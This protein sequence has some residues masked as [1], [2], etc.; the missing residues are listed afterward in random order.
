MAGQLTSILF[1]RANLVQHG[2]PL[3]R[4]SPQP[5]CGTSA[6]RTCRLGAQR[7]HP[8]VC[9]LPGDWASDCRVRARRRGASRVWRGPH[10]KIRKGLVAPLGAVK[11]R[12]PESVLF[13]VDGAGDFSDAVCKTPQPFDIASSSFPRPRTS[14]Y[15]GEEL[16]CPDILRLWALRLAGRFN[17]VTYQTSQLLGTVPPM[18]DYY[19]RKKGLNARDAPLLAKMPSDNAISAS[20]LGE[21][22]QAK[23]P[24]VPDLADRRLLV[25]LRLRKWSTSVRGR[26]FP[27]GLDGC[28]IRRSRSCSPQT[29]EMMSL[30]GGPLCG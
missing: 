21:L 15:F 25:A 3:V 22:L 2:Y 17:T 19:P 8:N 14:G 27:S 12:S 18:P 24:V 1:P 20:K 4:R 30:H 9:Q 29:R 7:Q 13:Q 11:I 5:D 16:I 28:L 10:Q 6:D 26:I 23:E